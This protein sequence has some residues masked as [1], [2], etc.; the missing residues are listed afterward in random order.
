MFF[1]VTGAFAEFERGMIQARVKAGL[2]RAKAAGKQ[3]GRARIAPDKEAAIR[4]A[5]AGGTGVHKVARQVGV[6]SGTGTAGC[7]KK[8]SPRRLRWRPGGVPCPIS[9]PTSGTASPTPTCCT[10]LIRLV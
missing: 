4:A 6:G 1:Q 8:R 7:A 10:C 3:L 5:L 9:R 2:D